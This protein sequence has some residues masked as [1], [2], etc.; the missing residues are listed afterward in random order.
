MLKGLRNV[1]A[2]TAMGLG[3]SSCHMFHSLTHTCE[4]DTD[5]YQKANSV[6]PL[7]VPLGIDAPDS[8]S[9]LQIPALNEPA[10][11]PRGPR[12]PCLDEPPKFTEPGRG[13]RPPPAA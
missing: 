4:L 12:D 13:A 9:G 1:V 10:P 8:K 5:S 7:R 3:L 6:T 11:P 2:V